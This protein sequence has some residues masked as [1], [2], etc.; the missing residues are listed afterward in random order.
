[1]IFYNDLIPVADNFA[2]VNIQ[3]NEKQIIQQPGIIFSFWHCTW[4]FWHSLRR[5]CL[6]AKTAGCLY[7]ENAFLEKIHFSY[8]SN[9]LLCSIGLSGYNYPGGFVFQDTKTKSRT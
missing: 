9:Y 7:G 4:V 5:S 2:Q 6:W 1:M 3:Q 8:K